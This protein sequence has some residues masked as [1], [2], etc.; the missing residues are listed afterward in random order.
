MSRKGFTVLELLIAIAIGAIVISVAVPSFFEVMQRNRHGAAVRRVVNDLRE[1]RSKAIA[2][3]WEV[4]VVGYSADDSGDH[5]NQYRVFARRSSAVDW[6]DED[7]TAF[8][9]STQ[10]AG[11]W[12]DLTSHYS[13]VDFV[14]EDDRFE[15]TFD[16]RGAAPAADDAF[17]PVLVVND[18]G[19]SSSLTVSV[20][21]GITIQ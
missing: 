16:S 11:S 13:D 17:N 6:P 18:E 1:A 9:T 7:A 8:E 14:V 15:V 10:L 19:L 4:R 3:G 5:A 12:F 20:V 2:T 21:G